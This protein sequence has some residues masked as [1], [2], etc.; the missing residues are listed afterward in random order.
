MYGLFRVPQ[1]GGAGD[2]VE[3]RRPRARG[4][5]RGGA[6]WGGVVAPRTHPLPLARLAK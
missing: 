1:R 6:G 5:G 2:R 3:R 4:G